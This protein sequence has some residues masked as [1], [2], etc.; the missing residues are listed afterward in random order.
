MKNLTSLFN[1][2]NK[3]FNFQEVDIPRMK[4]SDVLI[5]VKASALCGT[6]LHVMDGDLIDKAYDKKNI[7]LGHEWAGVITKKG[8]GVKNFEIGDKVFG[9]PHISCGKCKKCKE[10]K[11]N[12]CE[13]QGIFGLSFP[14]SH[15]KFLIA[16]KTTVI[17][18]PSEMNF[19]L[20]SLLGDTVSTAY[21]AFNR[22]RISQN[23]KILIL[24]VGPV[25]LTIGLILKLKKVKNI[26]VLENENYRFSL[27][28]KLFN[29]KRITKD[30]FLKNRRT[31]NFV[32][33]TTGSKDALELGFQALE[34]GGGLILIG[35]HSEKYSLDTLRMMYREISIKGC[36]GYTHKEAEE[37]I[38]LSRNKFLQKDLKTIITHEIPLEEIES[39]YKIFRS[40]KSGKVVLVCE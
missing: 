21:H 33:E 27:A 6:D 5:E 29:A 11:D 24:G 1:F 36:F 20:G 30:N 38:K 40:K 7:T 28:K 32:F 31:F 14:G 4:S 2:K 19:V 17:K 9:T 8:T 13:K 39:A 3:K 26:F 23:D 34:R 37:F 18:M 25:G 10:G 12:H 22:A 35:V 15:A 16:P